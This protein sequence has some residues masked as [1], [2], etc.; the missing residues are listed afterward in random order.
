M[1]EPADIRAV[2]EAVRRHVERATAGTGM[3]ATSISVD[4]RYGLRTDERSTLRPV[5][6]TSDP[7]TEGAP[8]SLR[9]T[10]SLTD[11]EPTGTR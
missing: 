2:L 7:A 5:L 1:S 11:D 6:R 9:M 8:H 4:L 3:E 10:F